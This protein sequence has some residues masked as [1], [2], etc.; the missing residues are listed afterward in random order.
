MSNAYYILLFCFFMEGIP[1]SILL[2]EIFRLCT[3]KADISTISLVSKEFNRKI[4]QVTK[5]L[6]LKWWKYNLHF[7]HAINHSN[8]WPLEELVYPLYQRCF[9]LN[10]RNLW[11][12][13]SNQIDIFKLQKS[14]HLIPCV[15]KSSCAL[16]IGT[17]RLDNTLKTTRWMWTGPYLKIERV[18]RDAKKRHFWHNNKIL[19]LN[20]FQYQILI[21]THYE[22]IKEFP[23]FGETQ[24]YV[25]LENGTIIKC[26]FFSGTTVFNEDFAEYLLLMRPKQINNEKGKLAFLLIFKLKNRLNVCKRHRFCSDVADVT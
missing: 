9:N 10:W 24:G 12:C 1:D 20:S 16:R 21:L 25:L 19:I 22:S 18:R 7:Q 23:Q 11:I 3:S 8:T 5:Q 26:S 17:I 4:T 15:E 2:S 14:N 13:L 6:C